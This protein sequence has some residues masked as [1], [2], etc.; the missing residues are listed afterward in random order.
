MNLS[1]DNS[2]RTHS[3]L[4]QHAG[5][6][7]SAGVGQGAFRQL[8]LDDAIAA[9]REGMAQSVESAER[10]DPLFREKAEAA[11][12]RHLAA[13]PDR[14]APGE[15][16]TE[17]ARAHG[18]ECKDGR[19]FGAVFLSLARRGLIRC[20]RSDL[21]RKRGHGSSGGKLWALCQ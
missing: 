4:P 19:A 5:S 18:A 20:L 16:L 13:S 10:R 12:L 1:L 21:P 14:C 2:A 17:V 3:A 6:Q 8:T 7:G 9:G 15:E 11:I